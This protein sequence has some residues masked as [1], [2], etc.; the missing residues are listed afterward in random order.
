MV[1]PHFILML[2]ETV[3]TLVLLIITCN[4]EIQLTVFIQSNFNIVFSKKDCLTSKR[5]PKIKVLCLFSLHSELV[6]AECYEYFISKARIGCK[7]IVVVFSLWKKVD[8]LEY[9]MFNL[10][11]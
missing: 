2:E 3:E 6:L 1:H 9:R 10:H 7:V 8:L 11:F 4:T 5:L